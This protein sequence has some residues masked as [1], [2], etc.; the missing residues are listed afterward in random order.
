MWPFRRAAKAESV[1]L[2]PTFGDKDANSLLSYVHSGDWRAIRDLFATAPDSNRRYFYL[3]VLG[4]GPQ[5][6]PP[7]WLDEWT[8][9]E[10][11]AATP[12]L[13][14]AVYLI[15]WAWQARTAKQ[16]KYVSQEQFATFFRRLKL[17]ED[18]LDECIAR[19]P[20][21]PLAWSNLLITAMGRQLGLEEAER[22]FEQAIAHVR[23][24]TPAHYT[25][26]QHRCAKW[27]GSDELALTFARETV[28]GMPAG[29]RL[30]GMVPIAHFEVALQSDEGFD[31]LKRPEV[32]AEVEAAADKSIRHPAFDRGPGF[33]G[34]EGWFAMVFAKAGAHRSAAECFDRIGDVPDEQ[35]WSYLG[36]AEV[37]YARTRNEVRR[38]LGR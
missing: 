25:L 28:A 5:Q 18:A 15:Q 37:V 31:Y 24:N 20:D 29:H 33:Q 38:A 12:R 2:D 7:A 32:V 3:C 13:I 26:L 34:V 16:A 27:G 1:T 17:A 8:A 19:A 21:E 9:A 36:K 4:E 22:R 6:K 11:A 14:R 35:P 23:W 30:G 10:P